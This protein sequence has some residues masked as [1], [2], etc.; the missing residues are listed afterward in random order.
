MFQGLCQPVV[1]SWKPSTGPAF[2]IQ[3]SG[4]YKSLPWANPCCPPGDGKSQGA[5]LAG[6]TQHHLPAR[7]LHMEKLHKMGQALR[8]QWHSPSPSKCVCLHHPQA[9]L[10]HRDLLWTSLHQSCFSKPLTA[11]EQDQKKKKKKVLSMFC[12]LICH[13]LL[14]PEAE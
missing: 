10:R 12:S 11:L 9:V 8:K 2:P 7:L 5:A 1:E 14:M 3:I 13:K 4:G 6:E